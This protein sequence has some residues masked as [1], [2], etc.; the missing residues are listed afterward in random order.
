MRGSASLHHKPQGIPWRCR[1]A[2]ANPVWRCAMIHRWIWRRSGVDVRCRARA[3]PCLQLIL[4]MILQKNSRR[5]LRNLFC[6]L[7]RRK[8][9]Q[10]RVGRKAELRIFRTSL[11]K[12]AYPVWVIKRN[13]SA[14][15]SK[16]RRKACRK[17]ASILISQI[18][19]TSVTRNR[20]SRARP[21]LHPD[22]RRCLS[23][24]WLR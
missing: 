5:N 8:A 14:I 9:R 21:H 22:M 18:K 4:D 6:R 13:R 17:L 12:I 7:R 1:W 3:G 10:K 24:N 19:L 16:S 2:H 15:Y 11:L 20:F 23:L